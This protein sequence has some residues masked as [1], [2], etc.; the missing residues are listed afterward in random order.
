M[1]KP[2]SL[3]I[4]TLT[5]I[6]LFL[7]YECAMITPQIPSI[8]IFKLGTVK[9]LANCFLCFSTP[10]SFE[11]G[12]SMLLYCCSDLISFYLIVPMLTLLTLSAD[13]DTGQLSKEECSSYMFG[14]CYLIGFEIG[15]LSYLNVVPT[16]IYFYY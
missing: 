10:I 12:L 1:D 16:I 8:G 3:R 2:S 7:Q 13:P 14:L 9:V 15:P 4:Y 11:F 6:T 5:L